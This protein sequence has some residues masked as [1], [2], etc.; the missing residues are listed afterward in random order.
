M[1]KEHAFVF[2]TTFSSAPPAA[3]PAAVPPL[4]IELAPGSGSVRVKLCKYS[5]EQREFLKRIVEDLSR[6]G[7]ELSNPTSTWARAPLLVPKNG[8]AKF[9]FTVELR[10][11]NRATLKHGYLMPNVEQELQSISGSMVYAK[12]DL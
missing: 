11:V 6:C 5:Q 2:C 1:V 7:M 3:P 9:H 8:P 4:K 10:S 12:L